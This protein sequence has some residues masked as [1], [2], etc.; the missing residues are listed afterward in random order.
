MK[1]LSKLSALIILVTPMSYASDFA[2]EQRWADQTVDSI[3]DGD[4]I[5]LKSGDH[6]FLAIDT[7]DSEENAKQALIVAHGLGIHPNWEQ[8]IKPIRV[9]MTNDGWRTLSIQMPIL[10]NDAESD[11]YDELMPEVA[12]RIDPAI[13]YLKEQGIE[14]IVLVAHSMGAAMSTYYFGNTSNNN[15]D[16]FIAI[17]LSDSDWVAKV[18]IPMLEIFGSNDLDGVLNGA[19][20]R[21]KVAKASGI[22]YK[23]VEV[24]DANHFFDDKDEELLHEVR[25]WLAR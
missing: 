14:K 25:T 7:L 6:E 1:F 2:K 17:G 15:I 10:A 21:G 16:E 24:A 22:E 9:E 11:E 13:A 23:Q 18:K 5:W 8:V 4:A 3:L 12:G 20:Y 19:A